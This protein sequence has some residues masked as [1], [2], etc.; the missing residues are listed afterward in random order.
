M[1]D[2]KTES[3]SL[4]FEKLVLYEEE[5]RYLPELQL[6]VLSVWCSLKY[7]KYFATCTRISIMNLW[8]FDNFWTRA[9]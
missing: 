1:D 2:S 3:T 9:S 7:W 5:T 4:E 8:C 6:P